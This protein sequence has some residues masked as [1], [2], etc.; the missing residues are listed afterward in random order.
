M[1]TIY[2]IPFLIAAAIL[3]AFSIACS[4]TCFVMDYRRVRKERIARE[5]QEAKE[6][7]EWFRAEYR[8][9]VDKVICT[10]KPL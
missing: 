8:K 4:V 9:S 1:F 2:G 5:D 6:F 10:N 7:D 3:L